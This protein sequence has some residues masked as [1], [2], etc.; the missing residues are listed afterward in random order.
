MKKIDEKKIIAKV[1]ESGYKYGFTSKLDSD[2]I[3]MGLSENVI[4]LIS[5]KKSEP[6]WM[7]KK[8]LEAFE[9]LKK[10]KQPNWA[11]IKFDN[12]DL[13]KIIYYSAPKK[14]L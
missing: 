2:T 3:D 6:G 12:I 9:L 10:M 11:N 14:G 7:L 8:R 5:K 1:T 13:Q 4:R